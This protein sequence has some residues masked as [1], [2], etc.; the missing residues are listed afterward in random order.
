ML[1]TN[2]IELSA[3]R[4]GQLLALQRDYAGTDTV[5]TIDAASGATAGY[6]RD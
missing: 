3:Y 1:F 2:V 5:V 6:D 4:D